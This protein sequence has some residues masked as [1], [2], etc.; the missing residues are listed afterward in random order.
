[1]LRKEVRLER[2]AGREV[3]ARGRV[4]GILRRVLSKGVVGLNLHFRSLLG[5]GLRCGEWAE[6]GSAEEEAG[7]LGYCCAAWT[8][9]W[10]WAGEKGGNQDIL[11]RKSWLDWIDS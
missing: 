5:C 7:W 8:G 10:G 3:D 6:T 11:G 9:Q 1:M 4:T 2:E